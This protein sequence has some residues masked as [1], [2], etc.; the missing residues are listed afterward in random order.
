MTAMRK[1]T[2]DEGDV[3]IELVNELAE[4]LTA[5]GIVEYKVSKK[6]QVIFFDTEKGA[7]IDPALLQSFAALIEN[8]YIDELGKKCV[9]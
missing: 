7:Q 8:Y 2:S 1:I 4:I 3:L 9:A 5:I 6:E